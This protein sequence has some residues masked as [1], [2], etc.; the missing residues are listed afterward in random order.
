[1]VKFKKVNSTSTQSVL[2]EN[3]KSLRHEM[4]LLRTEKVY[5]G[6]VLLKKGLLWDENSQ[7]S[8][9]KGLL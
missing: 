5:F 6:P 4:A 8:Y 9:R 3:S 1:M 2:T 7:K